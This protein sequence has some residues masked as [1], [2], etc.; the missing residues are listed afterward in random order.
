MAGVPVVERVP[1]FEKPW[2]SP[3]TETQQTFPSAWKKHSSSPF[4]KKAMI[5]LLIIIGLSPF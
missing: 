4:L 5:P 1:Q 3:H 2:P